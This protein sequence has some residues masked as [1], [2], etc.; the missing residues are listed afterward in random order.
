ML[1]GKYRRIYHYHLKKCGGTTL[2]RWLDTLTLDERAFDEFIWGFRIQ[3]QSDPNET[4]EVVIPSLAT[5][6]VSLE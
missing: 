2:N 1:T 3:R 4:P 6:P 5:N